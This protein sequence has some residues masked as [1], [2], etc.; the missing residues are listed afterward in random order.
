ML[1]TMLPGRFV[2]G[3]LRGTTNKYLSYD[4]NPKEARER[5]DDH[6][7]QRDAV[8]E[9]HTPTR[10]RIT[11]TPKPCHDLVYIRGDLSRL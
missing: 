8:G 7:L 10:Q 6:R 2:F 1:D 11:P 3:L 5:T 4:L 9:G